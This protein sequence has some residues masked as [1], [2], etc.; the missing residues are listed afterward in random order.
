MTAGQ[1]QIKVGCCGFAVGRRRYLSTLPLVE[2]NITFYQPPELSVVRRWRDEAPEDFEFTLKAWQLITHEA[3]SPTYRRLHEPLSPGDRNRVGSFRLNDATLR[4]WERTAAVAR[5][6]GAD[7]VLFQCPASFRPTPQNMDR[8]RAFFGAI[9]REGVCCLWEP[10]G[11][12]PARDVATLC[13]ELDLIH[14]V[15]PLQDTAST[16]GLGYFRLHGVG[17][18]QYRYSDDELARIRDLTSGHRPAYVLFNNSSEFDDARRFSD[19]VH[20]ARQLSLLP[21]GRS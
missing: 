8:L 20:G 21:G 12:W 13:E 19:L 10:R 2:I 1:P 17:G 7:K 15:D 11:R 16:R 6:L 9:E 14:C 4:A 3:T 18:Y 5:C